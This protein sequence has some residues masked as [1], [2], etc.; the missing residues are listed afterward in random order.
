MSP[1]FTDKIVLNY[2]RNNFS[3]EFSAL[4]YANPERNQY[5][6]RLDGFDAGWQHTD[7]SKRFAYYN[8]LKS[9]TYTFYVKSSNSNGIWDENVQTVK[10]V[11]LP[12]PWKTWWAYT[13]YIIILVGIAGYI[14]RIIR[15]RIRLRN[16]LHLREMEQAKSEE[17]NHAKL[18][19]FTNITHEL[20]TPLTI[21]SASVDE[22][23]Q[24]APAYKE[25]Y[26]VMT[27]NINRLIRL[28]QQILEFRKAET[29]NLK[30][31]VL[32]G[33][34]V[35]FVRRSLDGFRPL[36][37]KKDIHFTI[38][39]SM[40][41]YLAFFDPDK[42]DKILYNLLSNASKYN[43]PGGKVGIELSC[44]EANGVVCII[45]KDNGPG[46][47]KESQKNLFKRFL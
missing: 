22:L 15:N 31:K 8:N 5:A 34:L 4:E 37:K 24:T 46:I 13:L 32:Q 6:Y 29:G 30:L 28:L 41:K 40:N 27:H 26:D 23:K 44:D 47:P 17:I 19:F 10:V 9:G 7:A 14:Y 43:K 35:L 33:D 39:S 2:K 20:L 45:V 18:Q 25:Q 12:P 16:A 1:R 3:I 42:L 38:Q 21:I 36:M 11:I